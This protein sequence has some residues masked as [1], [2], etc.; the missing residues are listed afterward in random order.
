MIT[1]I[2]V[3]DLGNIELG[4]LR[5]NLGTVEKIEQINKT[6]FAVYVD[7]KIKSTYNIAYVVEVVFAA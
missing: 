2:F 3:K 4:Q 6:T 1:S 7:G 5:W